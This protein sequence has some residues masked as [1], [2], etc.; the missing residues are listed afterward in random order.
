MR[1]ILTLIAVALVTLL[2]TALIVPYFVDWSAH[3]AEIAERLQDVTG[4]R[5]TL[6]GPVTLRLLPTP[7]LEVGAGSA[8][9]ARPDAPRLAFDGAR[10]E[11]ALVKLA[12]G[13]F[14]FT[15]VRLEKPVLTLS[16]S[17]DGAL[18]L[19]AAAST[20]AEAVGADRFSVRDG[21]IRIAGEGGGPGWTIEGVDLDG[22]AP[23]LA[24]PYH[25][26]GRASGPG[27]APIVFRL[28]SEKAGPGGAPVRIAV[29]AGPV[30]PALEFDGALAGSGTN[31]PSLLG[32][33]VITG[34]AQGVDGPTPWRA[35][36]KLAAD[37]GGATLTGAEFRFGPEERALRAEGSASLAMRGG[38][39]V[40]VDAK[41]REANVDALL[42][43]NG[44]DA[45]PPSRAAAALSAVL[46]PALDGARTARVEARVAVETV[47]LG[48]DT[49]SG[50][51]AA[52]KAEPGAPPTAR[53][54]LGLPG[55]SR[56]K[57][58]GEVE[59]GAAARFVGA[60]DFS[61]GNPGGLGRWASEGAPELAAFAQA[62]EEAVPASRFA[63]S[64]QVEAA[65]V[66]VSG[67]NLRIA[68]GRSVLTGALAV[69]RPVGGDP[70]R[71]YADLGADSL[72]LDALPS[73]QAAQSLI[74]D[75]DLSL[76]LEAKALSLAHVG[77]AGIDGA[78]LV[79]KVGRTG[80]NLTLDRLAIAGLGGAALE[81]TGAAGP[82][83]VTA[84]G[85]LD[86]DKLADFVALVSRLAPGPWNRTLIQRAPF[87][88]PASIAFEARGGPAS[89]G[90]PA[91][92]ALKATGALA[93]TRAALS[94]EPAAK[95]GGQAFSIVLNSPIPARSRSSS[96]SAG[97]RPRLRPA[98]QR[99]VKQTQAKQTQAKQRP[100][101]QSPDRRS[102]D[103]RRRDRRKLDK[104]RRDKRRRG[105]WS[106]TA[107]ARGTPV[108]TSTR[109]L[110][111]PAPR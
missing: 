78:S 96:A 6:N 77:E 39:R 14:R 87:L 46:A 92:E 71:I 93:S 54:E 97:R 103:Q 109:P 106:C 69:T 45:A 43:R 37:L 20:R 104:R 57:A 80:P 5:V 26:N 88:S 15:D 83:G 44:E 32:A 89:E 70:G 74:G 82:N 61:T 18:V 30:W 75:Y 17:A 52:L 33:A 2:T 12:S 60:I 1:V 90:A 94:L 4:G 76:S 100:D 108:S 86:A 64:G 21:T 7:Y 63:V 31:G 107:R 19:P 85:R 13:A 98:K 42:R 99:R 27:G 84:A 9:G 24:G 55:E 36:G 67:R 23:T 38:T 102:L 16:R 34:T 48:G 58:E 40:T 72:D 53:F 110:R 25:V 95:G 11:L 22:D 81:A 105:T 28:A 79:L 66:G 73:F 56:I 50:L 62:L 111:S 8:T 3:R 29:E 51:S 101:K 91:L 35:V 10:L 41:A 49:I 59:T 68:L 47:I 65:T